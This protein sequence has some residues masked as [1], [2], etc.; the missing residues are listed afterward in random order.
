MSDISEVTE[1]ISTFFQENL[2]SFLKFAAMKNLSPVYDKD[3]E[4]KGD[5]LN[6]FTEMKKYIEEKNIKDLKNL[7]ILQE[8]GKTPAL[9]F[10]VDPSDT[11]ET[12]TTLIYS[13]I[14]KIPFGEGWTKI[15]PNFPKM[16]D[17]YIYGRGVATGLYSIFTI[18]SILET[19]QNLSMKRPK[20]LVLLESSFESGSSDLTIYLEKI[21]NSYTINSIICLE[22]WGPCNDYF[23]YTKS[24]RGLISFDLKITTATKSVH[25]GSFGGLI[26][27]SMMIFQNIMENKIEKIEKSGN[28][29]NILIPDMEI[30]ITDEQEKECKTICD[31]C[32]Y[33]IITVI[34]NGSYS[35]LIGNKGED[36]DED[37]LIS[38]KN[39]VLRPSCTILGFEN[40]PDINNA[41]G[42]LRPYLNVRLCF[43]TPPTFDV[44]IG[45]TNLKTK[46]TENV[47]FNAKIEIE[48]VE[49]IQGI[50]LD[51]TN[52]ISEDMLNSIDGFTKQLTN[53][54]IQAFRICDSLLCL[55]YLTGMFKDVPILVTG[56]GENFTGNT[57]GGNECL[58]MVR[59]I[60][61]STC[62]ACFISDF[63][64]YKS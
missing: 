23:H 27:D 31:N 20:M 45:F 9:F 22:T 25:S 42:S 50:D 38:Y 3:W 11:T 43:R 64:N 59:I 13:H 24:T 36:E 47:P 44:N 33:E 56:G 48:N 2:D 7:Q 49:L 40:I 16:I 14:D 62:L 46:L 60:K 54:N 21:K 30:T 6:C 10:S 1:S 4:S 51:N 39:G 5:L 32:G 63:E 12:Y 41:S 17:G 52:T 15:D 26:P 37:F 19:M 61:F 35:T 53:K 58:R 8:S 55:N 18:L 34:P 57:R 28:A 29:T